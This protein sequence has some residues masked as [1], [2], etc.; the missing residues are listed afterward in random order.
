V[1]IVVFH[2]VY[3]HFVP[4]NHLQSIANNFR[5]CKDF[6]YLLLSVS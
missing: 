3:R 5:N 6:A 4:T 2:R 1:E